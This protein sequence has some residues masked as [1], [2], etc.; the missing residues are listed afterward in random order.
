MYIKVIETS[1]DGSETVKY[2]M[3]TVSE[4]KK[5][6]KDLILYLMGFDDE[7]QDVHQIKRKYLGY[8]SAVQAT[9]TELP[10]RLF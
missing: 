1:D 3:E 5:F 9:G 10:D 8:K 2:K 6:T 7:L 4:R